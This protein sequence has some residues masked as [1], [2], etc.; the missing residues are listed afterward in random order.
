MNQDTEL[1]ILQLEL[2][3]RQKICASLERKRAKYEMA[4]ERVYNAVSQ[5]EIDEVSLE[6]DTQG[7][8]IEILK[9]KIKEL[10]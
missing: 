4:N 3:K 2:K 6:I 1:S 5:E 10:Q 9:T 8:E 7:L